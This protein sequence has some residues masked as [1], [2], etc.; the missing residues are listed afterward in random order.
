MTSDI[1]VPIDG[2]DFS[3]G[4]LAYTLKSHP[5]AAVTALHVQDVRIE[6][7]QLEDP[8]RSP[9]ER[10]AERTDRIL[11]RSNDIADQLGAWVETQTE[12][13]VPHKAILEAV[14]EQSYDRL[15][16]GSHGETVIDRPFLGQ[17]AKAVLTRAPVPVT[18]VPE[19]LDSVLDRDLPGRVLVPFDGSPPAERA[20]EFAMLTLSSPSITVLHVIESDIDPDPSITHGTYAAERLERLQESGDEILERARTLAE[21]HGE[22]IEDTSIFGKPSHEIVDYATD[23]GF[24]QVVMGSHGRTG[25]SR[26]IIGSV[27]L[28]VAQESTIPVT[29]VK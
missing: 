16:I 4:A 25:V 19:G 26:A 8:S 22:S 7:S 3:Y 29:V 17:A 20:L 1:L 23:E 10:I 6:L 13:G 21:G 24:D 11:K 12:S 15:C 18:V 2:S 14:V 9:E 28:G 5:N 27:A